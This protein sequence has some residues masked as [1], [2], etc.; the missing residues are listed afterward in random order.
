[1]KQTHGL[2]DAADPGTAGG[3]AI[4]IDVGGTK[5]AGGLVNLASGRLA[6]RRQIPT[7]CQRGGET[8]LADV[9]RMSRALVAEA[10]AIGAAPDQLGIGVAELVDPRG[11]VFSD[12]LIKW[13]G[14]DVQARLAPVLPATVASDVRAAALAEARFGAGRPYRDFYYVSLGTGVSGVLVQDSVPYAGSRGA[15]LVIASGASH[16]HCPHCGHVSTMT[17]EEIASGPGLARAFGTGETGPSVLAAAEAGDPRAIHILDHA[18]A[19]LGR[20]LALLVN[21]LD[22]A[23]LILGGGLGSAPGRYFESLKTAIL[24]GLWEGDQHP[25]PILQA[26]FGADAGVVGAALSTTLHQEPANRPHR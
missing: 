18:A 21:S 22:P 26:A 6:L 9:E 7:D 11:R 25:L 20:V 10:A 17:V 12:H 2:S 4:G 1:M 5:I 16:H 24:A 13:K 14:I 19:E 23:A 15:A 3:Y 8:V